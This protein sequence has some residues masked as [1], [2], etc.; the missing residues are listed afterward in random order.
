MYQTAQYIEYARIHGQSIA[1]V[2]DENS[3]TVQ[4]LD[5]KSTV[6]QYV[7]DTST[8][9]SNIHRWKSEAKNVRISCV[10]KTRVVDSPQFTTIYERKIANF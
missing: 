9:K 6:E 2:F 3:E 7:Y 8:V 1:Q 5:S 10:Y 4:F